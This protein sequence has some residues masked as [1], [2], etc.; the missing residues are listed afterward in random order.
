M[1]FAYTELNNSVCSHTIYITLYKTALEITIEHGFKHF[2]SYELCKLPNVYL[3]HDDVSRGGKQ[4]KYK[5]W[6][7]S[8][9]EAEEAFKRHETVIFPTGT[10]HSHGPTPLSI[11][12]SSVEYFANE[13]GKATGFVTLPVTPFGENEKQKY[14]PGSIVIGEETIEQYYLDVY[15]SLRRN[16]VRK[17]LV[18]NGHGGNREALIR[19]G[20]KA[21]EFGV[22]TLIAEWYV[23]HRTAFPEEYKDLYGGIGELAVSIALGGDKPDLRGE[24]GYRGEWG[25]GGRKPYKVRDIFGDKITTLRFNSFDFKGGD[26]IIPVQAWDIDLEGPPVLGPEVINNLRERAKGLL[27]LLTGYLIELANEFEKTDLTEALRSQDNF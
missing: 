4:M 12:T 10:F 17:V 18:L 26:L 27:D 24:P 7:M 8:H 15:R 2:L 5:L 25:P 16:G 3:L 22:I 20:R 23:I 6:D 21:R 14:Y 9:M 13:V 19:A 11:D 1:D